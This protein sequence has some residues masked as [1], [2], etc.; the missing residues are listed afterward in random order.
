MQIANRDSKLK[1]CMYTVAI[2]GFNI[3][4]EPTFLSVNSLTIE[5]VSQSRA[6][7][8]LDPSSLYK[9]CDEVHNYNDQIMEADNN[10]S[11]NMDTQNNVCHKT[12]NCN[13][14]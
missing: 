1:T 14:W 12:H 3:V 2:I 8:N 7:K 13:V 10:Y 11:S 6:N 4:P 5:Q 9:I